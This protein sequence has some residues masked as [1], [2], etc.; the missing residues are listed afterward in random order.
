MEVDRFISEVEWERISG[1]RRQTSANRRCK[2]EGPPYYKVGRS[3]RYKLSEALAWLERH[4]IDPEA[5]G[6][7]L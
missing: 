5:R 6:A 3:V 2:G 1:I 4:R 7:A